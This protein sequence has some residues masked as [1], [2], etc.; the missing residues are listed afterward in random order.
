MDLNE[1]KKQLKI[2]E[3]EIKKLEKERMF[4]LVYNDDIAFLK[5]KSLR[6]EQVQFGQEF[7]P[8]LKNHLRFCPNCD[9]ELSIKMVDR[10]W[11]NY[12]IQLETSAILSCTRCKYEYAGQ[13]IQW[14]FE[15]LD[16]EKYEKLLSETHKKE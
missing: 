3:E 1:F 2:K 13:K 9:N 16:N 8:I 7:K 15:A 4:S 6:K 11:I 10:Q 12:D 14:C 5:W